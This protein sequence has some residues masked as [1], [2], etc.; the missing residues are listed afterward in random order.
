M[1]TKFAIIFIVAL[2]FALIFNKMRLPELLGMLLAGV[3]LGPH[4]L[5]WLSKEFIMGASELRTAAL[6]VILIRAGLGINKVTLKRVGMSAAKMSFIPCL[7]EGTFVIVASCYILKFPLVES[8]MLGFILAAVSPAVI[9]PQM[10]NLLDAGYGKRKGVPTLILASASI[11]DVFAITLFGSFLGIALG[12]AGNIT[13]AIINIP[14]RI[15]LGIAIGCL[16]G[17]LLALLFKKFEKIRDTKK[18][19]IFIIS[20]I[21]L[22]DMEKLLPVASLVGIMAMGFVMLEKSSDVAGQLATK[23]NKVW[24]FAEVVLF[25]L[26]GAQVNIDVAFSSG[27]GG[28][29]IIFIGL[30]GRSIGVLISLIAS[31]LNEKERFFCVLS[32]VPK[33]TVQAAI[34]AIPLSM[35]IPSGELILAIAVLSIVVTAPI[36]SISIKATYRR[37]LEPPPA[38]G[39]RKQL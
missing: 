5:G 1:L 31:H 34:G 17:Y 32:Y 25:V 19:I 22:Y 29:A 38:E 24:V 7:F 12:E 28:L 13:L 37:L 23:F 36:G 9:V 18:V 26:I 3:I 4:C 35:G 15:G 8:G 10:L 14:L 11:D 16:F 27:L 6:I 30:V 33:A 2:V 20:A 21:F 39:L